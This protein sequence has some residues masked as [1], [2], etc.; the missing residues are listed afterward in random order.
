MSIPNAPI[1]FS[2][3]YNVV[4]GSIHNGSTSINI[5]DYIGQVWSDNTSVPGGDISIETHFRGKS[6]PSGGPEYPPGIIDIKNFE[7]IIF[8]AESNGKN[9]KYDPGSNLPFYF[10]DSG[11]SKSNYSSREKY[12]IT[13]WAP[14]GLRFWVNSSEGFNY[15]QFEKMSY[16]QYDR[17]GLQVSNNG[18][19]ELI[20]FQEGSKN[21]TEPWLQTS[22]TL[23]ISWDTVE[24]QPPIR[25]AW[26]TSF[27]GERYDSKGSKNGYIFPATTTR[28][29]ELGH[30][31][32]RALDINYTCIRFYFDSD[33]YSESR[34]WYFSVYPI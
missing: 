8:N 34:G 5:S 14:N 17:L 11:G 28:A 30:E 24:N 15:F 18:T 21:P 10:T 16:S 7:T 1:K 13:F 32:D 3:I 12:Y 22:S 26:S 4:N 31:K 25:G 9:Y 29:E 20:N 23:Q 33:G 6:M 27:G 19:E 2:D